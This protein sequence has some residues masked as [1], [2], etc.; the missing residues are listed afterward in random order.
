MFTDHCMYKK[1]N[2]YMLLRMCVCSVLVVCLFACEVVRVYVCAC[3][4]DESGGR[5][6]LD[7]CVRGLC[8]SVIQKSRT[9]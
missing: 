2:V 5:V 7:V 9:V 1:L 4:R 3:V 8:V 6:C